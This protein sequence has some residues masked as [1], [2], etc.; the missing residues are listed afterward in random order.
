MLSKFK[1]LSG[2]EVG[3]ILKQHGFVKVRQKGSHNLKI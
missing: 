1:I 2:Q 3:K